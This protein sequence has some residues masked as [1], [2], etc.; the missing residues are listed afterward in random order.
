MCLGIVLSALARALVFKTATLPPEIMG[1][2]ASGGVAFI[3][4]YFIRQRR[5]LT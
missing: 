3:A 5:Q 4:A 2:F 1:F